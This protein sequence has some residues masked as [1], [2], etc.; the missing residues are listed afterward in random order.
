MT[1]RKEGF[2]ISVSS[3][4][5]DTLLDGGGLALL[6]LPRACAAAGIHTLELCE[7]HFPQSDPAYLERLAAAA[8]EAGVEL[9]SILI[10]DGDISETDPGCRKK[11]LAMIT[12]WIDVAGRLG[13]SRVRVV[14]GQAAPTPAA[15]ALSG[16]TLA[17]LG[18]Y[19]RTRGV[20]VST[21]N[22]GKLTKRAEAVLGILEAAGPEI[23]LCADFG[24]FSGPEKHADLARILP[25]ATS[26]HVKTVARSDGTPDWEEFRACLMLARRA[27]FAGPCSLIQEGKGDPW[28]VLADLKREV[29]SVYLT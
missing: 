23:G 1:V 18:E 4:S 29:E 12:S 27:G 19:A 3:W 2:R 5:L 21:E 15:W 9:Y 25:R 17:G 24:N 6:D 28:P 13:A 11:H 7:F 20:A 16:A 14:A 22:F 8:G 26:L 10:D